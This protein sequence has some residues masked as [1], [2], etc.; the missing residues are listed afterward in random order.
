MPCMEEMR[1]HHNV[2]YI[3]HYHV[4]WCPKYRR[5]VLVNGIDER[6]KQ[7]VQDVCTERSAA[8]EEIEVMP[9]HIQVLVSCD[10]QFGIHRLIR[11]IKGRSSRVLR[12]EYPHLKTRL[13]TL[14]TNA[15][16]VATIGGAPLEIV[17]Q[18]IEG[19]KRG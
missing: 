17:K 14:W 7:I 8:L 15:Y 4:V 11:L 12:Q 6:L 18:Y 9:D 10:P 19:Q 3:T 13:P 5:K 2:S 1:S 16:F